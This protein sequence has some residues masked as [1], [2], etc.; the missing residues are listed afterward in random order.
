SVSFPYGAFLHCLPWQERP[1]DFPYERPPQ[2][3]DTKLFDT[4]CSGAGATADQHEDNHH[5]NAEGVPVSVSHRGG[6]RS[7][8][9]GNSLKHS[10]PNG[11]S[12]MWIQG[13]C[14]HKKCCSRRNRYEHS[15]QAD[16]TVTGNCAELSLPEKPS[17]YKA[18]IT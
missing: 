10:N 11:F 6:T 17:G 13:L 8:E 15:Y 14:C 1:L 18:G 5:K 7:R 4:P 9:G 16:F 12:Q 2:Q 3:I